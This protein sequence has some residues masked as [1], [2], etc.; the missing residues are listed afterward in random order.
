M[1]HKREYNS[2]KIIK[3]MYD[4]YEHAYWQP[5]L[6]F[7]YND[8]VEFSLTL[9]SLSIVEKATWIKVKVGPIPSQDYFSI[10]HT[11][12]GKEI[13]EYDLSRFC[14]IEIIKS[15]WIDIMYF[16]NPTISNIILSQFLDYFEILNTLYDDT[17]Y[18]ILK[19]NL[20]AVREGLLLIKVCVT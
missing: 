3:F 2:K 11:L 17:G 1:G 15:K 8:I 16:P 5:I 4:Q 7:K 13:V 20:L 18:Y 12:P 9:I 14:E 10:S 19:V 6:P